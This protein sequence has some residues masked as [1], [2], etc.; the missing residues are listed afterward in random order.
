MED[1]IQPNKK[2][3]PYSSS[4][5]SFIIYKTDAFAITVNNETGI[6]RIQFA[7]SSPETARSLLKT[8]LIQGGTSTD[9]YKVI[10]FK[11]NSVRSLAQFRSELKSSTGAPT[12][13]IS[14]AAHMTACLTKQLD[15]LISH[16]SRTIIGYSAEDIIVINN[17]KFAYLGSE[18]L[19]KIDYTNNTT[20]LCSP[21][22]SADF[23]VSPELLKITELPAQVHYKTAYFSLAC[24]IVFGLLDSQD[25]YTEYLRDKQASNILSALQSHPI[26]GTKLYWLLSRCLL[27]D[28]E[29]RSIL[30][31]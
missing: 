1:N 31:I 7:Y 13:P 15:H 26:H 14:I 30:L 25:F 24:L 12:L 18:F 11:A 3:P 9:N 4:S 8:K 6:F 16:E 21:F 2:Q 5:S 22:T 20:Q 29:K 27:E 23:F 19:T 10:Q 28:P 17:Q